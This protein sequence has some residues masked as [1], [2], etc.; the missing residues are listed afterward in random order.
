MPI[1]LAV[2]EARVMLPVL[3]PGASV[4]GAP[5]TTMLLKPDTGEPPGSRMVTRKGPLMALGVLLVMR[6]EGVN[7]PPC[8]T[9]P[10]VKVAVQLAIQA[11]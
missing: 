5:P 3:A 7:C 8:S 1:W 9:G 2:N 6:T 11:A 10:G 4:P